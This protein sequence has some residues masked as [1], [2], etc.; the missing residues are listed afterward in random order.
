MK[1]KLKENKGVSNSV[2]VMLVIF[3][4]IL[5][6][7]LFY[8]IKN[9]IVKVV[10]K[11][12]AITPP[13]ANT[14]AVETP[15]TY[16]YKDIKGQYKYSEKIKIEEDYQP[17]CIYDLRLN[18]DGT[19]HYEVF[20]DT[21]DGYYGNYF[22]EGNEIVLNTLFSHGS[23]A[24]F[25]F[26]NKTF[27]LKINSDGTITDSNDYGIKISNTNVILKRTSTELDKFDTLV[28]QLQTAIESEEK[29]ST[30]Y[31]WIDK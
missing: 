3:I 5:V 16:T 24:G 30:H 1:M 26:K 9:P 4:A 19:F 8:F 15:K 21:P 20:V 10:E 11:E 13:P 27:K 18:D 29:E 25:G 7:L 22:I 2:V 31:F 14:Q 28:Y 6:C 12:E 23:G 17:E